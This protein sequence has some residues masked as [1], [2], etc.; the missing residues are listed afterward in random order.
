MAD[1]PWKPNTQQQKFIDSYKGNI[2][3]A[4]KAAGYTYGYARKMMVTNSNMVSA[5]RNRGV[6]ENAPLVASRQERQRFW[7]DTMQDVEGEM[8]DR[9]RASELLGKSEADFTDKVEHSGEIDIKKVTDD[10]LERKIA[11]LSGEAGALGTT[12]GEEAP[13]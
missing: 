6:T 11:D 1:K 13:E 10:E 8:K 12:R 3:E 2:E 9:L 7:T 5:I 4:A